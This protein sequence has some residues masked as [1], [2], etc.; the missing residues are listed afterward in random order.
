M[1]IDFIQRKSKFLLCHDE[2]ILQLGASHPLTLGSYFPTETKYS[3]MSLDDYISKG[4]LLR[5]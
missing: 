3:A 4:L 1:L 2:I 5:S